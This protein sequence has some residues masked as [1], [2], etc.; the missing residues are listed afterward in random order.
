[1]IFSTTFA[2]ENRRRGYFFVA[3]TLALGAG[4]AY[5]VAPHL[6]QLFIFDWGLRYLPYLAPWT[7]VLLLARSAGGGDEARGHAGARS[8]VLAGALALAWTVLVFLG[9][10]YLTYVRYA[11]GFARRDG[12]VSTPPDFVRFTPLENACGDIGNSVSASNE[13]VHCDLVKPLIRPNGLAYAALITPAGLLQTFAMKNP[14]F[15]VLDDSSDGEQTPERRL[16]RVDDP[17]QIGPDMAWF[18]G[19]E[20][21]LARTDFF[22]AYD[23]PHYLALD[24]SRPD[25]LTVAVPK[26]K[27]GLLFRLPYWGGVVLVHSDGH[28]EDLTPDQAL[29]DHRLKQQWIYP[30]RLARHYVHLQNYGA[31]WGPLTPFVRVPGRLEIESLPGDNQFPFL[32][33]AADGKTYFVTAT[34]GVGSAQGLYRMYFVDSHSGKG[35]F[36]EFR[37]HEVAYGPGAG[38]ARITNIPGYQWR[39][40]EGHGTMIAAE[41]VYVLRPKDGELYW[42]FTITN[43]TFSGISAT[44]VARASRPDDIR[45]FGRRSELENWLRGDDSPPTPTSS[46]PAAAHLVEKIDELARR[47]GELR[48]LAQSLEA[49][50]PPVGG[51]SK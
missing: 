9:T 16:R 6:L 40:R 31:G 2:T 28:V 4:I 39:T 8:V 5:L 47:V 21:V 51:E 35:S 12:L 50:G 36:Y 23:T 34:K 7:L 13:E 17:Q 29:R 43:S 45:V 38:L 48:G 44:A 25:K 33:R 10:D 22:A 26:I 42:K 11:S 1:M 20:L 30:V 24:S 41:P 3:A 32:T 18:D 49:S 19:L 46:G 15:M 14:G 27:F 37:S